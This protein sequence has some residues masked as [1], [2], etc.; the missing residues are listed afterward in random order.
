[1]WRVP[2]LNVGLNE[3]VSCNSQIYSREFCNENPISVVLKQLLRWTPLTDTINRYTWLWCCKISPIPRWSGNE[4][5]ANYADVTLYDNK[6]SPLVSRVSPLPF[7]TVRLRRGLVHDIHIGCLTVCMILVTVRYLSKSWGLITF[8]C[9][10]IALLYG[11][12]M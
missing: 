1:M 3:A 9:D 11:L 12:W 2:G 10:I 4:T 5:T 6:S 7:C 8:L